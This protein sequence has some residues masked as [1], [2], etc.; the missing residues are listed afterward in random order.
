MPCL[1]IF[2]AGTK[3]IAPFK[4]YSDKIIPNQAGIYR[5]KFPFSW[6]EEDTWEDWL[7][8]NEFTVH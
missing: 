7:F 8:S 1:A 3:K 4:S 6:H 5:L 2:P